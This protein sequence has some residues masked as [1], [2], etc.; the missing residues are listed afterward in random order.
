MMLTPTPASP[1]SIVESTSSTDVALRTH[2][3]HLCR[4]PLDAVYAGT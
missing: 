3:L 4:E 2:P 1:N